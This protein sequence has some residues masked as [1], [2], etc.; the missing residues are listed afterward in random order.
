MSPGKGELLLTFFLR[1][2]IEF[3]ELFV[4]IICDRGTGL[5]SDNQGWS[6]GVHWY[7][8]ILFPV[9]TMVTNDNDVVLFPVVAMVIITSFYFQVELMKE[10][11]CLT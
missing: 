11:I 3:C 1:I 2:M 6:L 8:F 5:A 9:V 10:T 7:I 4:I